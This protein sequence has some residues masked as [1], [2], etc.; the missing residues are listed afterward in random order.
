LVTALAPSSRDTAPKPKAASAP[1]PA[2]APAH[3]TSTD[4]EGEDSE[5]ASQ[6]SQD[7]DDDDS[8]EK[9]FQ[10]VRKEG[11]VV[12]KYADMSSPLVATA[13]CSE[14]LTCTLTNR[15]W[16]DESN[17]CVGMRPDDIEDEDD[18]MGYWRMEVLSPIK[19]RGWVSLKPHL[20]VVCPRDLGVVHRQALRKKAESMY[21]ITKCMVEVSL[22]AARH[23]A[24]LRSQRFKVSEGATKM[25]G[26]A[27][28]RVLGV[29]GQMQADETYDAR[30][31]STIRKGLDRITTVFQTVQDAE[32]DIMKTLE[33]MESEGAG[34]L[35]EELSNDR[36]WHALNH[37]AYSLKR[38]LQDCEHSIRQLVGSK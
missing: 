33:M 26:S 30:V 32:V 10:V 34:V 31:S 11:V 27:D 14:F 7:Y 35:E 38:E 8:P 5:N 9:L 1:A 4:S 15:L 13:P 19:F 28:G 36:E 37:E 3:E 23:S 21:D 17:F 16:F 29:L 24:Q 18:D 6:L 12:R 20:L 25:M 22:V 2:P